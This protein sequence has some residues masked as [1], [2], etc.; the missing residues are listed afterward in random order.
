MPFNF[1]P[2]ISREADQKIMSMLYFGKKRQKEIVEMSDLS[3]TTV[4]D[5]LEYLVDHHKVEKEVEKSN[6]SVGLISFI[7]LQKLSQQSGTMGTTE[8]MFYN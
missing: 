1:D 8:C 4:R 5:H 7:P 6:G 3:D 2:E